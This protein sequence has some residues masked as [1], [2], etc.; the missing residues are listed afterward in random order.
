MP[1]AKVMHP[2]ARIHWNNDPHNPYTTLFQ[3]GDEVVA[4]R[5]RAFFT[6]ADGNVVGTRWEMPKHMLD[7]WLTRMATAV[8]VQSCVLLSNTPL[9]PF[10]TY[11]APALPA[12]RYRRQAS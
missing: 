10:T 3:I 6:D 2:V 7:D 8:H 1:R 5:S 9:K 12:R 4:H 11:K